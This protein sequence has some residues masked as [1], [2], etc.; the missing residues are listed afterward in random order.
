M[1]ADAMKSRS[2]YSGRAEELH[3][4][5]TVEG[6]MKQELKIGGVFKSLYEGQ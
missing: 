5:C 6:S 4:Q 2:V 3:V 1:P